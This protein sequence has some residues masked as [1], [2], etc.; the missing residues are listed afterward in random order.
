[1]TPLLRTRPLRLVGTLIALYLFASTGCAQPVVI[2]MASFDPGQDQMAIAGY[3][4]DQATDLREKAAALAE[5][6]V[7][8][9]GLF[10]P[11]S[12]WVSG[13]RQLSQYYVAASQELEH[14][15]DAHAEVA[16][17]GRSRRR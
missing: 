9:E 1:M 10:G 2:D 13:A 16:R 14:R 12:D 3:Y 4:R 6:A 7:R 17:T 8:Y 15:A 11:Q 5:S